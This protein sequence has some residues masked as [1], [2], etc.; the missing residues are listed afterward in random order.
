MWPC[1]YQRPFKNLR[2]NVTKKT[3]IMRNGC[4]TVHWR[5][6][7]RRASLHAFFKDLSHLTLTL[8]A[9]F[10]NSGMI[11][12]LILLLFITCILPVL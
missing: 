5:R 2:I 6:Y 7:E 12:L 3:R 10:V 9:I 8:F 4:E 11:N 1:F